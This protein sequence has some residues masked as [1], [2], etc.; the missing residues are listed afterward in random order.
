MDKSFFWVVDVSEE[1]V[2]VEEISRSVGEQQ[3]NEKKSPRNTDF[4][5]TQ[6]LINKFG[7]EKLYNTWKKYGMYKSAEILTEEGEQ[8]VSPY[9]MRYM[10]N[11][12]LVLRFN[13]TSITS[14]YFLLKINLSVRIPWKGVRSRTILVFKFTK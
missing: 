5:I 6:Q 7:V 8:Y 10:S 1:V 2:V 9:V 13:P 3:M 12:C 4:S 14:G 11:S